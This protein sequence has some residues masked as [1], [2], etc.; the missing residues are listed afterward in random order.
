MLNFLIMLYDNIETQ[1]V[2]GF[3][4]KCVYL[5]KE[6]F[7]YYDIGT[8]TVLCSQFKILKCCYALK[9]PIDCV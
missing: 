4:L 5:E 9:Y 2:C 8:C 7:D 3:F 1:N 6:W